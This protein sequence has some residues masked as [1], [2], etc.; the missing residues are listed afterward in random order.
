VHTRRRQCPKNS[1]WLVVEKRLLQRIITTRQRALR[2][3]CE[4]A[5]KGCEHG[6]Y[7]EIEASEIGRGVNLLESQNA[8]ITKILGL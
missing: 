6:F 3:G 1:K 2:R 4:D 7:R 8:V 5:R